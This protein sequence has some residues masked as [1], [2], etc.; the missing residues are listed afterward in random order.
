[1]KTINTKI[2][3]GTHEFGPLDMAKRDLVMAR[4]KNIFARYGYD[5]IET[6]ILNL[7]EV[8]LGKYGEEGDRLTYSFQDQGKRKLALPYD[9][10]VPFARYFAAN[11]QELP[12]PF[13][14]YQIQRVWRADKPQ[15]GRLREF[16]QCDIDVIGTD[17]LLCEAEV[18]RVMST[19][20]EELGFKNFRI[21]TNSRRLMNS[22][23]ESFSVSDGMR[24]EAIRIIDKLAKIGEEAVIVELE[25][26]G[27]EEAEKLITTIKPES[28]TAATLTKL[29]N[30]DTSEIEELLSYCESLGIDLN[31]IQFN[32][33][34]ARGL[35]YYTGI[36]FEVESLDNPELGS[37]CAGGRYDNLC[38]MFCE[39]N[40][41]GIGVAFG[42][43]R[44]MI[45]LEEMG[46][47]E[48]LSLNTEVL[49]TL[50]DKESADDALK[51][52]RLLTDAGMNSEI[53]F[54]ADKLKKQFK[55]ADKKQIPFVVIQ[56][57]EENTADQVTVKAMKS[58]KQKTI[59]VSQLTTYLQ[60]YEQG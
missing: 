28:D 14:R 2:L 18:A 45:A 33:S 32:P 9:L 26:L 60:S 52:Y 22:I 16:Y 58:G 51:I 59:P 41:S 1:M 30:Y 5:P 49:V 35:D 39:K 13:K 54:E 40:F 6:P 25:K 42:F 29:A 24:I 21:M 50:F 4:I 7:A 46:A 20:F 11:W 12:L 36:I 43:E 17:S 15:K 31:Y 23:L 48:D 44:I 37:I 10:T 38:G 8:I 19:V 53:Y 55:Y 56:G 57:P 34:L 47:F 27:V 3:K